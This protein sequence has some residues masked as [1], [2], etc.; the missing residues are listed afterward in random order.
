M[1]SLPRHRT[2]RI[3]AAVL[4]FV[5]LASQLASFAHLVLVRHVRC[6]EHGEM[7]EVD[8]DHIVAAR[9]HT[10]HDA[11]I[12]TSASEDE[13]H[14]HCLMVPMRRDRATIGTTF[15]FDSIHVDAYGTIGRVVRA[16]IPPPIATLRF[17][18]KNSPP[19]A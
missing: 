12:A 18:P 11:L 13:A 19:R 17:A 2:T 5:A 4:A 7:I 1:R 10:A 15:A 3:C 6:A 16:E 9:P 8:D 14:D